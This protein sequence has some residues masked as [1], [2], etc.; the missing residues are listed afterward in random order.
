LHEKLIKVERK[1]ARRTFVLSVFTKSIKANRHNKRL[2]V[3]KL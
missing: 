2:K 1:K 3:S